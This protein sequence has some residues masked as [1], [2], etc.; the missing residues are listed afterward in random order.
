M[1]VIGTDGCHQPDFITG[2]RLAPRGKGGTSLQAPRENQIS[3]ERDTAFRIS[4]M[5]LCYWLNILIFIGAL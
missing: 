5:S 2:P 4:A 3:D 1:L